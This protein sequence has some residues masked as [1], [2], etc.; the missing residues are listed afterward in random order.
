MFNDAKSSIPHLPPCHIDDEVDAVAQMEQQELDELLALAAEGKDP[1]MNA[2]MEEVDIPSSPTRYGSD[3][4]DYDGIFMEMVSSQE[5]Q[6]THFGSI[7]MQMGQ[8]Y[9]HGQEDVEMDMS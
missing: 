4:E 2:Y 9:Y 8:D 1:I 3:D 6:Q 7:Q 5:A